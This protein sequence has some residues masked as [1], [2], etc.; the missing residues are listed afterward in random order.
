M[1]RPI[2][3][4]HLA[5]ESLKEA[6]KNTC[7]RTSG[8]PKQEVVFRHALHK[9]SA[10]LKT[11]SPSRSLTSAV[12]AHY[13]GFGMTWRTDKQ[14]WAFA[15]RANRASI[16][17]LSE[18]RSL[19]ESRLSS[20]EPGVR[21]HEGCEGSGHA[22]PYRFYVPLNERFPLVSSWIDTQFGQ[23]DRLLPG[24]GSLW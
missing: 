11:F 23:Q 22:A 9:V 5:A 7:F 10:C 19:L 12:L 1:R 17:P 14:A 13:E 18:R 21:Q 16:R 15:E 8:H 6:D 20:R 3:E 24:R 2:V 4:A